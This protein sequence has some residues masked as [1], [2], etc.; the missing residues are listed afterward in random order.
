[1]SKNNNTVFRL[2]RICIFIHL[3]MLVILRAKNE[4]LT[5]NGQTEEN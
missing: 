2:T 4:T 3:S 5:I 1:M